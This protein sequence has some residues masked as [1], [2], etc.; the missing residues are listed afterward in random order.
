MATWMHTDEECIA[1]AKLAGA[2]DFIRRLAGG[3][4][5]HAARATARTSARA[6]ASCLPLRVRLWL[7]RL[8]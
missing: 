7:I 2:D 5:H 8:S 1:A 4:Q 6:S 3:L